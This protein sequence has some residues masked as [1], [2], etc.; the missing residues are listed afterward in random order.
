MGRQIQLYLLPEDLEALK[1]SF[2]QMGGVCFVSQSSFTSEPQIL[3]EET[4]TESNISARLSCYLV[5]D[6]DLNTIRL[7]HIS[8]KVGWIV[9]DLRSPVVQLD[10]GYFDGRILRRGRIYYETRYYGDDGRRID[11]QLDFIKWAESIMKIT[12]KLFKRNP[13]FDAYIGMNANK[14]LADTNGQL[15]I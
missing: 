11:K 9:D 8:D 7:K 12:K 2:R 6:T 13:E 15:D 1:Q 10:S 14:W 4:R 5:R 3:C